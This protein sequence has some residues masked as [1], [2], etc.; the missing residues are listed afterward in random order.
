MKRLSDQ[1][2]LAVSLG[3]IML[4]NMSWALT[5]SQALLL[6]LI[7]HN[8]L[9]DYYYYYLCFIGKKLKA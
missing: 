9:G 4:T 1:A 8:D 3:F 2:F 7:P 6:T 5:M